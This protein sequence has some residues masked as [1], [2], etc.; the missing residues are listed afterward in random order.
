MRINIITLFPEMFAG[1]LRFGVCGRAVTAGKITVT[2]WNPRDY[3]P[4]PHRMVDD[5][6]YG[7]GSGMVLMPE[8]VVAAARAAKASYPAASAVYLT[9]R[10]ALFNDATARRFAA[11]DGLTLLCG[12]YRGIDERA[13]RLFA[14]EEISVGDY[15][16]SGGEVA[17]MVIIE[18]VARQIPGV[19][20]NEDS[21]EED[22]FSVAAGGMLDAPCYTRPA[23]FEGMAVPDVLCSGDHAAVRHWRAEVAAELTRKQRPDLLRQSRDT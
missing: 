4:L 12:R 2:F 20:G 14:G 5:R 3:A 13:V 19:L 7:G 9:P 1:F 23:V 21:A 6:P 17:A 10:G 16:L 18:A 11:T 8:P 15:V 22:S